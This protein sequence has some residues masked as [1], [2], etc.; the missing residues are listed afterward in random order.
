MKM[1]SDEGGV[2]LKVRREKTI[3]D[4]L[5]LLPHPITIV[6]CRVVGP[7]LPIHPG[8]NT[9]EV[10]DEGGNEAL[11]YGRVAPQDALVHHLSDVPLRHH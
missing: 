7:A 5:Q 8:M 10:G 2:L 1:K 6:L 11:E 3:S 4:S 9:D